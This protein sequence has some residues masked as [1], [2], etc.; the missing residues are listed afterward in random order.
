MR[1]AA[2]RGLIAGNLD[3]G[4]QRCKSTLN[5]LVLVPQVAQGFTR[6]VKSTADVQNYSNHVNNGFHHDK[7]VSDLAP[8]VGSNASTSMSN[9]VLYN[10]RMSKRI[11]RSRSPSPDRY[12]HKTHDTQ[13][14]QFRSQPTSPAVSPLLSSKQ[15]KNHARVNAS[16]IAQTP[17]VRVIP[18]SD[19]S[20]NLSDNT[21][22]KFT[23]DDSMSN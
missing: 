7:S 9:S 20:L 6:R 18:H 17:E 21:T 22:V 16:Y 1:G 12:S 23:L 2:S 5:H 19:S 15:L 13:K 10:R 3:S 4:I 11:K 8:L 14:R